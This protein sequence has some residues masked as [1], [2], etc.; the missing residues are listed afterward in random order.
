MPGL[1]FGQVAVAGEFAGGQVAADQ[2]VVPPGGGGQPRP[3][4]PA[5]SFGPAPGG[6]DFPAAAVSRAAAACLQVRV[7]PATVRRKLQG[8]RST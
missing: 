7:T 3:G 8:T 4:V 6:A 1:A 2:Q 5:L